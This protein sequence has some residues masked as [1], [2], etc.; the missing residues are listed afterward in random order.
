[1]R[2]TVFT[3]LVLLLVCNQILG[4]DLKGKYCEMDECLNFSGDQVNFIISSNGGL[5]IEM[6]GNGTFFLDEDYFYISTSDYTGQTSEVVYKERSSNQKLTVFDK[7]GN[8]L[9]GAYV[10]LS[11]SGIETFYESTTNQFGSLTIPEISEFKSIEIKFIGYDSFSFN[12]DSVANEKDI[13]VY[14][15]NYEVV[16]NK[17]LTFQ[18]LGKAK[19]Q[20]QLVL[21]TIT[22]SDDKIPN[23][24]ELK[25]LIRK[26][27][28]MG[29][30]TR[31]FEKK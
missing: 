12:I 21:L 9:I 22:P 10:R 15:A 26:G 6:R 18:I 2:K 16:E 3:F 4:Q 5:S 27:E 14:L 30:R 31:I 29:L 19:D 20:L 25:K 28:K 11:N 7:D 23:E 1:M 8:R 24:K 13:D 17:L